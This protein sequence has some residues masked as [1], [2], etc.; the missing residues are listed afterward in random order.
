MTINKTREDGSN[1]LEENLS[2]FFNKTV[3]ILSFY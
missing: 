2:S 1:Y 3:N